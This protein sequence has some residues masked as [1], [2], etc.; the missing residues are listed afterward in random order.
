MMKMKAAAA[1]LLLAASLTFSFSSAADDSNMN[2]AYVLSPTPNG[3]RANELFPLNYKDYPRGV[4]H[5]DVYSPEVSTLYSQVFW[6]GLP[7]VD[8]P[9]HIVEKYDG[10]G[11]AVVGFELD[12]VRRLDNGT[13]IS[14]PMTVAYNHHFESNMV[15]A[16][17]SLKFVSSDHPE[18]SKLAAGRDM[19]HGLPR[20][21]AWIVDDLAPD[22]DIPTNQAFGAANGGEVRKSFHGY[23]PGY[24]QVIHSPRQFQIT[25]MQIDTF[26]R[27]K[28]SVDDPSFVAGPLPRHSLAPANARYSGLLEC[29]LTTRITKDIKRD[30]LIVASGASCAKGGA[31]VSANDCFNAVSLLTKEMAA[32]STASDPKRPSGCS[33][34]VNSAGRTEA[35]YNTGASSYAK[36]G[37][38]TTK[39]FGRTVSLV[40]M[41]VSVD[42]S[43]DL[44]TITL[45]GPSDVWFGVGFNA[46][47]MS[48][49][50]WT[51]IV[52]G[53]GTVTERKLGA[54]I[55]GTLLAPSVST[56]SSKVVGKTRTVVVSRPLKGKGAAYYSFDVTHTSINYINAYG[57]SATFGYHKNKAPSS[58]TMLPVSAGGVCICQTPPPPFGSAEGTLVYNPVEGQAGEAGSGSVKF[59]NKCAPQPRTDL[60]AQKNPTCDVRTYVGGQ[61]ACHHMWSL[62]DADQAI[63]WP[64]QPLKYHLK[65][66]F[67]VQPYNASYHQNVKR[68]T[69]G[70]ASPVEFDVPK[71]NANPAPA[72]CSKTKDGDFVHTIT[73][74][75]QGSGKLVASHFHCHAPTCLNVALY[76]CNKGFSTC[77]E[78][79]NS[80]LLC[81]ESPIYGG[82][83]K[84]KEKRFDEPGFILQ[85]P[86]LWGSPEYGL[87]EPVDLNGRM[88][89]A[90]KTSNASF[91]HHGEMSWLQQLYV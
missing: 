82:T 58:I 89:Y 70:I 88:L 87:E 50:P 59:P 85:P 47:A 53:N 91:G 78:K 1:A 42:A 24:A 63:P 74:L 8:L 27:D 33:A 26:N 39:A 54:H 48:D 16:K 46:Q 81:S 2:G 68:T 60:L 55:P 32:N 18:Y 51:I 77:N 3:P 40:A 67:W 73:G 35:V 6:K 86:C 75:F 61:T 25:P 76:A 29:P 36:C 20:E 31:I 38:G 34:H 22:S 41:N 37:G 49:A 72:G 17:A 43:T 9:S 28:M 12:Q 66:R 90:I 62:L 44:V 10:I 83:G 84:I 56:V 80:T 7:P 14:V 52:D 64:D 4:E 23:A 57:S 19:G 71:C 5:F 15:G 30:I 65:F 45:S 79:E 21:G 11:M 13:D 69:W